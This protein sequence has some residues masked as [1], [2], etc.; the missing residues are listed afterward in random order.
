M[1]WS[2]IR[3]LIDYRDEEKLS[4]VDRIQNGIPIDEFKN[5]EYLKISNIFSNCLLCTHLGHNLLMETYRNNKEIM[6]IYSTFDNF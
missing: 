1:I 2:G 5:N 3:P 4:T 6:I